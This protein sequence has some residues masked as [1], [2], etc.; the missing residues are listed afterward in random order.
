MACALANPH[1]I[2]T[3]AMITQYEV[4]SQFKQRL[5]AFSSL[6]QLVALNMNIYKE[7]QQ[8]SAYTKHAINHHNYLLAKKCFRMANDLHAQGD[9]IV[10]NAIENIFVFSF[11]SLLQQDS[12]EKL[13]LKSLIPDTLYS[14]YLKQIDQSGY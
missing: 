12:V 5:P 13:I 4:P 1:E 6:P 7:L 2:I 8:F 10:R 9:T 11:S 14:L 3:S